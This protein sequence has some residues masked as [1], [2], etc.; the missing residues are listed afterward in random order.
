MDCRIHPDIRRLAD[1]Q[2][3]VFETP[4]SRSKADVKNDAD[5]AFFAFFYAFFSPRS[6]RNREKQF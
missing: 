5:V 4:F 3:L 1:R 2:D 6:L